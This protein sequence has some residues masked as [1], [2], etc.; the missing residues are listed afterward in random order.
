[1][2]LALCSTL[3][4]TTVACLVMAKA[5]AKTWPLKLITATSSDNSD[6]FRALKGGTNN[7]GIVTRVDLYTHSDYQLYTGRQA[8][9]PKRHTT[10]VHPSPRL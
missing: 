9:G 10:F 2:A 3:L 6:L 1:M 8:I 4:Q 7:F 5:S